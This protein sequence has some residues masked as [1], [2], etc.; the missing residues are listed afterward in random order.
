MKQVTRVLL[1]FVI[2]GTCSLSAMAQE[3]QSLFDGKTL[4][5]WHV[6]E[7]A[8]WR[9]QDGALSGGSLN[10]TVPSNTFL[11]SEG[12]WQ[13]FDLRLKIR[14]L[15]HEGFIN[16]GIQVRSVRVPNSNEMSGYQIDA[17]DGWWGKIW[18]ESRRNRVIAESADMTAINEAIVKGGWNEYRIRCEG[19]R[20]RSWINGIPAL[21]FTETEE[22]IAQE[23]HI[24]L[25]AHG[26]GKVLVQFKDIHIVNL[27][28]M[29]GLPTWEETGV[30]QLD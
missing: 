22:G 15:G 20:I 30:S 25:Q 9:V 11:V 24:G 27:A 23:G 26:G 19:L 4:S 13:N 21:D 18:D 28:D 6:R 3:A 16:S 10:E 17:G 5:G 29:P 1:V 2:A 7:P 8:M 14:L 12:A